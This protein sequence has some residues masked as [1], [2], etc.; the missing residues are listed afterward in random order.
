MKPIKVDWTETRNLK[1]LLELDDE[2]LKTTY[3]WMSWDVLRRT[4]NKYRTKARKVAS[5]EKSPEHQP[6][7]EL[8]KLRDLFQRSGID[9]EDV[10]RV[11]RVNVYQGYMKN[12]DGEFE[13]VDLISAQY[14]PKQAGLDKADFIS[15][16]DPVK[17]APSRRK[18]INRDHKV[19]FCFSDNQIDYRQMDDGELV[20]THDERLIQLARM[21]CKEYQPDTIVNLGDTADFAALSRFPN[22]SN[23]FNHSMRPA[24]NRIHQMYAELR[25]DNPQS[26]I[27]EVDSNHNDRLK[28]FILKN[29]PQAFDLRQAGED[30][31]YPIMSYPFLVN[32]EAVGVDWVGGYGAA[33]YLYGEEYDKPPIVFKHGKIVVSN[34]STMAREASMNPETHV[35]RGHSHRMES[36][37]RTTRNGQYL[38]YIMLGAS[39]DT[40]GSVPS[41]HSAV[42]ENGEIVRHQENWQN[43]FLIIED[44]D[45]DYVF[46][47]VPVVNG[48]V[49]FNGKEYHVKHDNTTDIEPKTKRKKI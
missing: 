19:I 34:G 13:T 42:N 4:R 46:N 47:H 18:P 36:F 40:T 20:P 30:S 25:A 14:V 24:I 6:T 32:L 44:Y 15:Q 23:H 9:P 1:N 41:Y 5:M 37:Y 27:V 12:A 22:D 7:P 29:F 35:V 38:G 49:R 28:K 3:Y 33:E 2:L 16:A 43:S 11:N 39:C 8:D 10:Q 48:V 21:M 31:K 26:K 45:G 17:I